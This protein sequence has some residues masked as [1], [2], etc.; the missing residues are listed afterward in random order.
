MMIFACFPSLTSENLLEMAARTMKCLFQ[1]HEDSL[2]PVTDEIQERFFF[3]A[4]SCYVGL[5]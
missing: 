1:G 2:C 3:P 5:I 4:E